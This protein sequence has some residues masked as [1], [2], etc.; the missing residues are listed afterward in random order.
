MIGFLKIAGIATGGVVAIGGTIAAIIKARKAA[1]EKTEAC[2]I[3][4]E[5]INN[6]F[7]TRTSASAPA[8][9]EQ[10]DAQA[11]TDKAWVKADDY[12]PNAMDAEE[13]LE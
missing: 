9:A 11:E 2:E 5:V 6:S 12:D 7:P 13:D 8:T 3:N 10:N 4:A 1:K